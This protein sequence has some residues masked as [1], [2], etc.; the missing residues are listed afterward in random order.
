MVVALVAVNEVMLVELAGLVV[1]VALMV[2]V[3]VVFMVVVP[4]AVN[5]VMLVELVGLV[6]EVVFVE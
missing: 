1:E 4:V 2:M 5:Q 3:E 6:V